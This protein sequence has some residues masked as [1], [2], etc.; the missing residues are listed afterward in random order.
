MLSIIYPA[1]NPFNFPKPIYGLAQAKGS[2][3][4]YLTKLERSK[5]E[6]FIVSPLSIIT[7]KEV[8]G[9]LPVGY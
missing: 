3:D 5:L 7:W 2:C 4:V 8:T 1:A 6:C 9:Q